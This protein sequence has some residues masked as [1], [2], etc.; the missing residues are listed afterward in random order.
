[1]DD[2]TDRPLAPPAPV[3]AAYIVCQTNANLPGRK[4][5]SEEGGMGRSTEFARLDSGAV[6]ERREEGGREN[7]RRIQGAALTHGLSLFDS[8]AISLMY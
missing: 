4:A 2:R 3:P 8:F 1:M 7:D 5:G 6:R